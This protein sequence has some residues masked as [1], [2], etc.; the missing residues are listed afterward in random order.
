MAIKT[1]C[2]LKRTLIIGN[3]GSGKTYFVK[4]LEK[5]LD[6]QVIHFDEYFWEPGGFNK[7]RPTDIVLQEIKTL[8]ENEKWIMEGVF[9]NLAELVI[10]NATALIFL[11]KTW[12]EC[13][14]ALLKRGPVTEN[15]FKELFVW[16]K[17]Y[18]NRDNSCSHSRHLLFFSHFKGKKIQ[19]LNRLES[20]Q[21]LANLSS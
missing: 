6:T 3:S 15:T 10:P 13:E 11:D 16:A 17:E 20:E 12:D 18:W 1:K 7:K 21:F 8:S 14:A 5:L 2:D 9:G 4:K 19:L